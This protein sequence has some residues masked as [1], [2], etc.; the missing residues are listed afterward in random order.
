MVQGSEVEVATA[1]GQLDGTVGD[2][3]GTNHVAGMLLVDVQDGSRLTSVAPRPA[4]AAKAHT[5]A[6]ASLPNPVVAKSTQKIPLDSQMEMRATWETRNQQVKSDYRGMVATKN[7]E[8]AAADKQA[9]EGHRL[10][11]DE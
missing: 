10:C 11:M 3:F 8:I 7:P 4:T 6:M 9:G 1:A 2:L 5:A